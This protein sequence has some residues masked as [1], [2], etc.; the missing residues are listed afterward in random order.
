M[1]YLEGS[2]L[3]VNLTNYQKSIEPLKSKTGR[4]KVSH[5]TEIDQIIKEV[6][7]DEIDAS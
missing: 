5:I 6:N 1:G 4:D 2:K 7:K 3:S